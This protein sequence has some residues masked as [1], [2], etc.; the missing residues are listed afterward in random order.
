MRQMEDALRYWV[1]LSQCFPCGS[2]KPCELLEKGA[3]PE[4]LFQKGREFRASLGV[5]QPRELKG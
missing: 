3:A 4:E 1:W 5:L 2:D